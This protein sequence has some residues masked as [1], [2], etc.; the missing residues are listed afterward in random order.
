MKNQLTRKD[1]FEG[2]PKLGPY[3]KSQRAIYKLK[4]EIRIGSVNKDNSHSWVRM[5]H[6][7]N[8]LVTDLIDKEYDDNKQEIS[9]TKTEIFAV[10]SRSK[11]KANRENLQLLAHR[12]RL[13][14]LLKEHELILNQELNSNKLPNGKGAKHPSSARRIT[15]RR[16]CDDRILETER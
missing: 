16:R 12:Q 1:G 10:A 4:V 5:S 6:G 15:S 3:W 13:Y 7:L 9:E 14:P 2:T 8:K 11:A